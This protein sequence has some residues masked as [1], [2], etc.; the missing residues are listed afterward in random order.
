MITGNIFFLKSILDCQNNNNFDKIRN[1]FK[2]P[3]SFNYSKENVAL[4]GSRRW[5]CE[6]IILYLISKI[7]GSTVFLKWT[8][9]SVVK[10]TNIKILF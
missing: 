7:L 8:E 4:V 2:Y 5:S 1:R 6:F 10:K 9:M 3:V